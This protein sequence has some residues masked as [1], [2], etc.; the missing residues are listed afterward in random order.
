MKTGLEKKK[1]CYRLALHDIEHNRTDKAWYT[2]KGAELW[3]EFVRLGYA[4]LL[5]YEPPHGGYYYK[6]ADI[7]E[8]MQ[9][10]WDEGLIKKGGYFYEERYYR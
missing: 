10:M 3:M 9:K 2:Q 7:K 6:L 8:A 5:P 1:F 4:T